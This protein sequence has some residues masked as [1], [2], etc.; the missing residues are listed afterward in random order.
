MSQTAWTTLAQLEAFIASLPEVNLPDSYLGQPAVDAAIAE[1]ERLTEYSPFLALPVPTVTT[2]ANSVN[3]QI[4]STQGLAPGQT[5]YFGTAQASAVIQSIPDATHVVLAS[6]VNTTM[7]ENAYQARF[8]DP[9]GPYTSRMVRGGSRTL[10]LRAGLIFAA[11]V[12]IGCDNR[13]TQQTL[14]PNT[15]YWPWPSD[16][17]FIGNGRPFTAIEFAAVQRGLPRSIM[18]AGQW[19]FS[20][21]IPDD[22]WKAEQ[23]LAAS[24]ALIEIAVGLNQGAVQMKAGEDMLLYDADLIKDVGRGLSAQAKEVAAA[25]TLI[26]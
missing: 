4:S 8:Y 14:S 7:D 17:P 1:W 6:A 18:V 5:V 16:A 19:G 25:Y 13:P 9:P 12:I 11:A 10:R 23:Q 26:S 22:A 21:V 24:I 3:Q 2:G 15:E 20:T